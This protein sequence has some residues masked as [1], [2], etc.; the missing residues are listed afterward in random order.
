MTTV[1]NNAANLDAILDLIA[2][3]Y[4]EDWKSEITNSQMLNYLSISLAEDF[5]ARLTPIA[6]LARVCVSPDA[7]E[8]NIGNEWGGDLITLADL[9][10]E[11]IDQMALTLVLK[12]GKTL[13]SE[14]FR[15]MAAIA[16]AALNI[17]RFEA[18]GLDREAAENAAA[19]L[20]L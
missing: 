5:E 7:A 11:V 2:E 8:E 6:E 12:Q 14:A 10:E 1:K 15:E 18:L 20:A 9:L 13:P 4:G 16:G 3:Q 19:L 17:A